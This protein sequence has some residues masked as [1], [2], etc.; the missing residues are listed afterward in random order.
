[1][2]LQSKAQV[3]QYELLAPFF[4]AATQAKERRMVSDD[5]DGRWTRLKGKIR[6]RWDK[7]TDDQIEQVQGR[8]GRLIGLLQDQYGG[9]RE[10]VEREVQEFRRLHDDEERQAGR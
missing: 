5:L 1:L 3:A 9:T 2:P 8:W 4:V 7:L 10:Q 6:E